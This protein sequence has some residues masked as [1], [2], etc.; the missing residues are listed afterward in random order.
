MPVTDDSKY[1]N[2]LFCFCE[3]KAGENTQK[4]HVMEIGDPAPGQQKIKRTADI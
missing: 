4:L 2:S 3:K 1:K